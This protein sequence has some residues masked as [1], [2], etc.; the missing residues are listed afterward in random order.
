[1]I[2]TLKQ[3]RFR[4]PKPVFCPKCKSAKIFSKENYG[5]L[6]SVYKCKN[7]NY[8]GTLILELDVEHSEKHK[9]NSH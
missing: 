9:G 5:I 8:E 7:C 3:I 6:P 2:E 1:M 4:T